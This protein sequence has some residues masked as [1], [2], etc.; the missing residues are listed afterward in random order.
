MIK[1]EDVENAQNQWGSRIVK[2][3]QL[4]DSFK[5]CRMYTLDFINKMYNF[6][7]G[8][9]QFKPT[10]AADKQFRNDIQGALSYFIGSD[11][12]YSED[13]GFAINPWTKVEFQNYSINIYESMALAMGNYFFK[14]PNDDNEIKVEYTFGY[15]KKN[16]QSL[17]IN[18]HHSS[19]PYKN[20]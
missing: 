18:L 9:V 13:G 3:G 19:L 7:N 2:I 1:I 11:S 16:M 10:K 14:S 17:A 6:E 12:D 5:E 4:K 20:N 8:S 15:I